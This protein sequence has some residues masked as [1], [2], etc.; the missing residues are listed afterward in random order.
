MILHRNSKKYLSYINLSLDYLVHHLKHEEKIGK[1][2]YLVRR[3]VCRR[4][5]GSSL[6][7]LDGLTFPPLGN[8][9]NR[10]VIN[11]FQPD[12]CRFVSNEVRI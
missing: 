2:I 3:E 12:F 1:R 7:F 8:P 11:V 9:P 10:K 4:C 5:E 6:F